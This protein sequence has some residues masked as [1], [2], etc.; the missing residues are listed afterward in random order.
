MIYLATPYFHPDPSVREQRYQNALRCLHH[1]VAAGMPMYSPIVMCHPISVQFGLPGDESFWRQFD[2]N[3]ILASN[4]VLFA[5]LPGWEESKGMKREFIFA[6]SKRISCGSIGFAG[7]GYTIS[8]LVGE[9]EKAY[10]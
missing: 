1:F 10:S 4:E 9:L 8:H 5:K 6:K 7:T 3:F 2:E